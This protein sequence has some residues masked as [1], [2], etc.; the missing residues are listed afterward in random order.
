MFIK[1]IMETL[2]FPFEIYQI[3]QRYKT[4]TD[5]ISHCT[6]YMLC[7]IIFNTNNYSNLNLNY[8]FIHCFI[9]LLIYTYKTMVRINVGTCSHY[10]LNHV[11]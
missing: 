5:N 8:C 1:A 6:L 11:N 7:I 9:Y 2:V 4:C 3:F 10:I